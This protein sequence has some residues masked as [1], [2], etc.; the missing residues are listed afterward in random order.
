MQAGYPWFVKFTINGIT[1]GSMPL[2]ALTMR[3]GQRVCWYLT[4][5]TID[6]DVR[7]PP[8]QGNTTL[9]AG[10][11][12]QLYLNGRSPEE[13]TERLKAVRVGTS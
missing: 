2:A 8:W 4:A 11:R 13:L 7:A 6:F 9:I 3:R 1:R 12:A 10:M 5:S